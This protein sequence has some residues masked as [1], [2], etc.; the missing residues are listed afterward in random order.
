MDFLN[1]EAYIEYLRTIL[2]PLGFLSGIFFA[3]RFILQW[4]Q[5]EKKGVPYVSKSFWHLSWLGN[6]ILAIHA[7]IQLQFVIFF[8]QFL[9]AFIS[10]RNLNLHSSKPIR[11]KTFVFCLMLGA[12]FSF[13][14][15]A[16]QEYFLPS[17]TFTYFRIPKTFS[18]QNDLPLFIHIIGMIGVIAFS[19][20][21]WVQWYEAERDQ[22]SYL[23]RRFFS[24]SI[25]GSLTSS[26][27]FAAVIDPVN[28]IGPLCSLFASIRNMI[29]QRPHRV[30]SVDV[31]LIA[32][33]TSGDL[34]GESIIQSLRKNHPQLSIGGGVAGKAMRN[35]G[36]QPWIQAEQFQVMGIVDVLKKCLSI[37]LSLRKIVQKIT[38][39]QPKVVVCIDQPSFSLALAKRLRKKGFQGKLVQVVAPTVWAYNPKRAAVFA[40][41]F[42]LILP[43]YRFEEPYFSSLMP[44]VWVGHPI[45]AQLPFSKQSSIDPILALF[46]G[47]RKGEV[48]RNLPLQLQ[49][50]SLLQKTHPELCISISAA[51][52]MES[53]VYALAHK[54]L[55]DHFKLVDFEDRYLLMQKARAAITKSGTVTL[56]LALH[57][58]PQVC[59][60]ETGL[61]TQ[62]YARHILGLKKQPFALPNILT[63][64]NV[65]PEFIIPPIDSKDVSLALEQYLYPNTLKDLDLDLSKA[66]ELNDQKMTPYSK[67]REL[68][69]DPNPDSSTRLD[70]STPS[71]LPNTIK[72][73]ILQQIDTGTKSADIIAKEVSCLIS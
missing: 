61:F 19:L 40:A 16:S 42:D 26:L 62:L 56:E 1:S 10:G 12:L 38:E 11:Q 4:Y 43:L 70:I 55:G 69:L 13:L 67:S 3:A 30:K 27:Y 31:V 17:G 14:I 34:L 45:T 39:T 60:Y 47:S 32:G 5:S 9:Q 29:L 24:I 20:R 28:C 6:I 72:S 57:E 2:Y 7:Y 18:H 68:C 15:F 73:K 22:K 71:S 64:E 33:E 49:A 50:A 25:I 35:L 46:P 8:L 21:F 63:R 51:R 23:S 48:K 65:V 41:Y 44:T 53:L 36:I 58:V 37:L 66:T 54:K 52:G 59:C